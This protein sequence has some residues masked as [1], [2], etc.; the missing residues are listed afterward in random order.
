MI[1]QEVIDRVRTIMG[2]KGEALFQSDEALL[3]I[4]SACGD[5][6]KR[7]LCL[8]THSET[9]SVANDYSYELPADYAAIRKVTFDGVGLRKTTVDDMDMY[10]PDREV[11]IITGVPQYFW[12]QTSMLMLYPAASSNGSG[13]LDIYYARTSALL[14]DA[15]SEIDLPVRFQRLVE[16]YTLAKAKELAEDY[17]VAQAYWIDYEKQLIIASGDL[18]DQYM[19]SY[20]AVR[21]V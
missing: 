20:P 10:Y 12:V 15:D 1:G 7:T 8:P 2:D 16:L 11:N 14:E 3:W 5:I 6:S 18:E 4:D 21:E 17:T 13:N 9:D 19:D